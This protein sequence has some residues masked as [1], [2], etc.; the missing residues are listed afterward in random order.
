MTWN[1]RIIRHFEN[2]EEY[3]SI[4]EVHYQEDGS[5][6]AADPL[7]VSLTSDMVEGLDE[8]LDKMKIAVSKPIL[9]EKDFEVPM[10]YQE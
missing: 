3:F 5:L 7:P 6:Y 2:G 1:F 10:V 8:L 9:D 4:H